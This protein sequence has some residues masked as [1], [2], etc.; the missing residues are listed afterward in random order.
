MFFDVEF[1]FFID[2]SFRIVCS[3]RSGRD[4]ALLVD[5]VEVYSVLVAVVW[6]KGN[7][8]EIDVADSR[9]NIA[10]QSIFLDL[11]L[12]ELVS[13]ADLGAELMFSVLVDFRARNEVS[14]VA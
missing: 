8:S 11:S 5:E 2:E 13:V 10:L 6:V 3:E 7:F 4:L 9:R 1:E 14:L 12:T